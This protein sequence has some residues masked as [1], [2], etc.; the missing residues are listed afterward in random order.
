MYVKLRAEQRLRVLEIWPVR[1][2]LE[3]GGSS[4]NWRKLHSERLHKL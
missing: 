4:R 1:G 3:E 2:V